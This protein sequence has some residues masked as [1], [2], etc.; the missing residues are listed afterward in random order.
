MEI[1]AIV[2]TNSFNSATG[3]ISKHFPCNHAKLQNITYE[4]SPPPP[5]QKKK[6][7]LDFTFQKP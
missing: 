7:W 3:G 5:L 2:G 1:H 6:K 4:D